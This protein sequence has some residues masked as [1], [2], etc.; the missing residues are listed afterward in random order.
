MGVSQSLSGL[1]AEFNA[2]RGSCAPGSAGGSLAVAVVKGFPAGLESRD[3]R[4]PHTQGRP[5]PRRSPHTR[6]TDLPSV[7]RPRTGTP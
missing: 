2:S 6:D 7:P 1:Q 3:D 5:Y 4:P